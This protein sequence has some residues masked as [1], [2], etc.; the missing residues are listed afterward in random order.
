MLHQ[1][2]LLLGQ[3]SAAS[4]KAH[5]WLTCRKTFGL[6]TIHA[7]ECGIDGPA[8]STGVSF[9]AVAARL[10]VEAVRGAAEGC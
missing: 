4:P 3:A 10:T 2:E 8:R 5:R 7:R 6:V 1:L 9:L